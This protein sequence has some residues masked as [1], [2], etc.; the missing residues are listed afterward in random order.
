MAK[1]YGISVGPGE[2]ELI[3]L[4][5]LRIMRE[6][7]VIAA[8]GKNIKEAV[9]YNIAI[10]VSP[11]IEEKENLA[12]YMPMTK[13]KEKLEKAHKEGADL[14][15]RKL[16]EGKNVGFLVLGDATIY[17]TYIYL[18]KIIKDRG[19]E[20]E[21]IPGVSSFC[22]AAARLS[23]DLAS[24]N[25]SIHIIPASYGVEEALELEGTKVLM[26]SGKTV[27]DLRKKLEG[28]ELMMVENCGME[29]EK[30]YRSAEE[31]PEDAGYFSTFIVK[32]RK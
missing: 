14:I 3:T 10:R 30:I 15:E 21:I 8:A 11:E 27:A 31:I 24:A 25:E 7:D 22:A 12:I 16:K 32:D 4:K 2:S 28:K 17:S 26:K 9:S 1:L 23:I 18:H 13:D 6:V 5:A 19:Y 20:V 29:D